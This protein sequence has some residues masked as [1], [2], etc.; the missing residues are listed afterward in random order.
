MTIFTGLYPRVLVSHPDFGNSLTTAN[1]ASGHYTLHVI[2]IVAVIFTPIVPAYPELDVVRLPSG[3]AASGWGRR[4]QLANVAA[5][6]EEI[7]RSRHVV[8][9]GDGHGNAFV[10]ADLVDDA[11]DRAL[12][13]GQADGGFGRG[14]GARPRRDDRRGGGTASAFQRL[15]ADLVTQAGVNAR[16]VARHLVFM[17]MAGVIAAFGVISRTSRSWSGA[18]TIRPRH[19]S[20][21]RSGDRPRAPSLAPR[22][23]R[24]RGSRHRPGRRLRRRRGS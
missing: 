4:R 3:S 1:A 5:R 22:R 24:G 9:T 2:T 23:R 10:T 15:W 14:P 20:D 21:H 12:E 17:A 7:P 13:Q 8:R 11:V 18:M 19:A 6:L 16:P